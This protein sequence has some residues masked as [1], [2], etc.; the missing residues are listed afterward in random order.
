MTQ[1]LLSVHPRRRG[2]GL[3]RGRD[4]QQ[5]F[6]DVD[7]F[8]QELKAERQLGLRRRSEP[9]TDATVVD[10]TGRSPG[11]R[12]PVRRDQGAARRVLGRRGPRPRRR[13]RD[14]PRGSAACMA[15]RRG[16]ARS[17]PSE[18]HEPGRAGAAGAQLAAVFRAEHGRVVA[19]LARRFGDL[20]LAEDATGEAL[21]VAAERWPAEGV[22]PNP[23]GWLTTVAANK[24][25]DRIRR[26]KRRQDKYAEVSRMD[27][28][29]D[30]TGAHRPGRGRPA[31]AACS[32]AATPRSRRRTGWRSRCGCS[33]G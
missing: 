23:G 21:L 27:I 3:R 33:A 8:N 1:Y 25:L 4:I 17:S 6:A 20:D 16:P 9:P 31:A 12:R 14:R 24:A 5:V 28:N 2:S 32:P 30:P 11:D 18:H 7:A 22:P 10:A 29:D 26:E 15:A 13:P 19:S